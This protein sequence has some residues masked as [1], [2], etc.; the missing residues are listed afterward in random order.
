MTKEKDLGLNTKY[1][2]EMDGQVAKMNKLPEKCDSFNLNSYDDST[3]KS[4]N[5]YF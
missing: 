1:A 3:D 5:Y 2:K 4:Y